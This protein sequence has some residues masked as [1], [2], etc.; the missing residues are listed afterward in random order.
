MRQLTIFCMAMMLPALT[1]GQ[2]TVISRYAQNWAPPG[3]YAEPFVPLLS[4]PSISF[5]N[6]SPSPVGASNATAGNVAGATNATLSA[7]PAEPVEQFP[8]PVMFGPSNLS[9]ESPS[10]AESRVE[11]ASRGEAAP[12]AETRPVELG[13]ASFQDSYGVA[14]L[15]AGSRAR[16][17][18][19]RLYSN[20]DI[21]RMNQMTGMVKYEGKTERLE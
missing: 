11:T 8:P 6:V 10:E 15:A 9:I 4:T 14:Q 19:K 16:Q 2:A 1:A 20:L 21:E 18:A 13:A 12:S 17:Q 7:L 5:E 3:V